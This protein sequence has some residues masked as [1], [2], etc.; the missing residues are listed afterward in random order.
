M[1]DSSDDNKKC[2]RK[3]HKNFY[4][5]NLI[6]EIYCRNYFSNL[7]NLMN[8][9]K[10]IFENLDITY[11]KTMDNCIQNIIIGQFI[12]ILI[13]GQYINYCICCILDD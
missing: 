6:M 5:D 4:D 12:E 3:S 2:S 7:D 10:K 9:R 13:S 11:V 1:Y 8:L